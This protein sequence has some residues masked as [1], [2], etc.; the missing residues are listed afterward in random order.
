MPTVALIIAGAGRSSRFEGP[1]AK[2]YL[3][4]DSKPVF[5]WTIDCF[6]NFPQITQRLLLVAPDDIS[7]VQS[8]WGPDLKARDVQLIAG[9]ACRFDSV[10]NALELVDPSV[11]LVAVHD[12]A[13]PAVSP[14]V[15]A[16]IFDRALASGAAMA[17]RQVT[18]TL[19]KADAHHR[20]AHV[21]DRF[22]YWLAQTPQV[23]RRD[24]LIK[25]YASWPAENP[26]PTDDAQ[27]VE[28]HSLRAA[29]VASGP[30]NIKI[31]TVADFKLL[32]SILLSP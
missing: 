24:L 1:V 22:S 14:A 15:I 5:L 29:L 23:F 16:E 9:G 11:D 10:S 21:P 25:A 17:A 6:K 4:I 7:M 2:T 26:E 27:V 13:R 30:E 32:E 28:A 8:K 31:T 12:A 19:K 3:P 18:E 20:A